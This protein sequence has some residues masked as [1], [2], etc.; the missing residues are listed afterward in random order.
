MDQILLPLAH[1]ACHTGTQNNLVTPLCL[2][3]ILVTSL[4]MPG[5]AAQLPQGYSYQNAYLGVQEQPYP[6]CP[7]RRTIT[8]TYEYEIPVQEEYG[9]Q[10]NVD[11]GQYSTRQFNI[12][13]QG[14]IIFDI[15]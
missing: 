2:G 14:F 11:V 4:S 15:F 1:E 6:P 10:S 13:N 9:A 3:T 12:G 7:N 8:Q 5:H